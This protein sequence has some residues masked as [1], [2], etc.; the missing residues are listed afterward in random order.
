MCAAFSN[1]F[2]MWFR[3]SVDE[4]VPSEDDATPTVTV[5]YMDYGN[6]EELAATK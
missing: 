1:V 6:T 4:V 2:K 5:F 3:V